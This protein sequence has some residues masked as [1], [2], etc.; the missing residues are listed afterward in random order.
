MEKEIHP[1]RQ[2]GGLERADVRSGFAWDFWSLF[3]MRLGVGVGE[4]G[5]ARHRLRSSATWCR[6]SSA[7]AMA[8]FMIGLPLGL[9]LSFLVSST[10]A[11]HRS[12]QEA[13]FVAG[14]PG[15]CWPSS[16]CSSSSRPA[17]RPRVCPSSRWP[18]VSCPAD[19]V[20]DHRLRG[21][22]QLQHVRAGHVPGVVPEALP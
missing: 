16:P 5:C 7:R 20:V 17:A 18:V 14:V 13:F 19:D 4:A 22:A 9:A 12:W 1:G 6:P 21:A 15:L 10:I 11:Q 8:V 3:A 2:R